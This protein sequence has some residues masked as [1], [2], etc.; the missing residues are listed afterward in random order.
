MADRYFF[1]PPSAVFPMVEDMRAVAN[2]AT[3]DIERL[4]ELLAQQTG[5]L[6]DENLATFVAEC[7]ADEE[8]GG[9]V[10]N[11]LQNVRP[12]S[13]EQLLAMLR[14]WRE[15]DEEN[16]QQFPDE[17]FA[18]LEQK[19]PL[20]IREYPALIRSKKAD[21][22]RNVL[23]NEFEG[24]AFICDARPVYNEQRDD[25]EGLIPL[26]T[27]KLIYERQNSESE[28]I[29]IIL[30]AEQL[31]NLV[32]KARQAEQKLTVLRES[33]ERWIPDG[34]VDREDDDADEN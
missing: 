17:A 14:A 4:G 7:I 31:E 15:S 18:D 16:R 27:M 20:L 8:Q 6:T 9:S 24:V 19:L 30:T 34:C 11:A 23:G 3:E 12:G 33:I 5:F 25:I 1:T 10:F 2:V 29:E 32:S 26:T 21:R 22:L 13:V 28:E